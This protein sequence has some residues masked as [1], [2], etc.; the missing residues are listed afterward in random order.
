MARSFWY[1]LLAILVPI[2]N[3]N[4]VEIA[5]ALGLETGDYRGLVDRFADVLF[6]LFTA[7]VLYERRG[8]N[9]PLSFSKG[10]WK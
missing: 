4:G 3:A 7:L 8:A 6:P 5:P 2:L 9:R 1:A 10:E